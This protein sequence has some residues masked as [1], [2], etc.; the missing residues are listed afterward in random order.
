MSF[1]CDVA[2]GYKSSGRNDFVDDFNP[3]QSTAQLGAENNEVYHN[4]D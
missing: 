3:E 2:N 1:E 4:E